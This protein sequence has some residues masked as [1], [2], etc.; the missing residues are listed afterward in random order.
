MCTGRTTAGDS[1]T[2]HEN[3]WG[4]DLPGLWRGI[5][6][7]I[8][9]GFGCHGRRWGHV[10]EGLGKWSLGTKVLPRAAD[11]GWGVPGM[12]VFSL[13]SPMVFLFLAN[14]MSLQLQLG[15]HDLGLNMSL[16]TKSKV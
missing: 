11:K 7:G 16:D 14:E 12:G 3:L 6:V 8:E 13:P 5:E 9:K 15:S 10:R 4:S 2:K 1:Y